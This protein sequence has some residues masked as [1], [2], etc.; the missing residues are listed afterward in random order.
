MTISRRLAAHR[1][2]VASASAAMPDDEHEIPN[3]DTPDEDEDEETE[4]EAR[5]KKDKPMSNETDQAAALAAAKGEG[6]AE[7]NARA[8]TVIS[9]E[10]Y[11]GRETLAATLLG[12]AKLTGEE[13]TTALA[14]AP[15]A[16]AAS[17]TFVDDDAT[18][19][20]EM[21]ASLAAEQ[22]GQTADAGEVTA[23][24]AETNAAAWGAAVASANVLAGY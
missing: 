4:A 21:R 20:A 16:M 1:A 23:T 9:S 24:A 11:A 15:K 5:K 13:I 18:A 7:A 17:A 12:N 6:F 14:A 3:P 8:T 19:R 22:P 2:A 10:H